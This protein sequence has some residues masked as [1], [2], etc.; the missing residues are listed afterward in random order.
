[1]KFTTMAADA[2]FF[3]RTRLLMQCVDYLLFKYDK[4]NAILVFMA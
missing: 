1:M 2:R 3:Q 4:R